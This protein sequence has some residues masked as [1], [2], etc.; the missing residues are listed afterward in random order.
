MFRINPLVSIL[1]ENLEQ[2]SLS[3]QVE[4]RNIESLVQKA[5]AHCNYHNLLS[6]PHL[7]AKRTNGRELL[8]DKL[9][10]PC[11]DF[12]RKFEYYVAKGNG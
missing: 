7:P 6:L 5:L 2:P 1:V 4:F 9:S 11:C 8:M 3:E 10:K 12:R